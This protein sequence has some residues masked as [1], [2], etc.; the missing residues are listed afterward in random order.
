MRELPIVNLD[1][2]SVL[3]P[4]GVDWDAMTHAGVSARHCSSCDKNV[5]DL[6]EMTRQ[7]VM[8]LMLEQEGNVCVRFS[9]RVDDSLITSNNETMK[10]RANPKMSIV[11]VVLVSV[12]L[13]ASVLGRH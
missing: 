1:E 12:V 5:Y 11:A 10:R 8:A 6:S 7:A 2:I 9:K 4:C 13:F 3:E